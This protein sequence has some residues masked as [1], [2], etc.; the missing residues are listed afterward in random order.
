MIV[1]IPPQHSHLIPPRAV[2]DILDAL[3]HSYGERTLK[4][5][6][7]AIENGDCQIWIGFGEAGDHRYTLVTRITIYEHKKTC[8]IECLGGVLGCTEETTHAL[9]SVQEWAK[10][11][12]CDDIAVVGRK[13]WKPLLGKHGFDQRYVVYGKDI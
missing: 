2:Q 10:F 4:Q 6:I 11:N 13:G 7:A 8:T 9:E 5:V 12:G 3:E 1:Q